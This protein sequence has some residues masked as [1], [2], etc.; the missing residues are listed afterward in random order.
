MAPA[1][2]YLTAALER[3]IVKRQSVDQPV[4]WVPLSTP[5]ISD[6]NPSG[7]DLLKALA[8]NLRSQN[9]ALNPAA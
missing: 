8:L 9:I 6:I 1:L 5:S 7:V 4:R 3:F 2:N